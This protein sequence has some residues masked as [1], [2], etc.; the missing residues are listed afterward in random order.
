MKNMTKE[1]SQ[2]LSIFVENLH[3]FLLFSICLKR[4]G[5]NKE[6]ITKL[7]FFKLEN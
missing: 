4:I 1:I 2:K 3:S 7:N 6:E 5:K